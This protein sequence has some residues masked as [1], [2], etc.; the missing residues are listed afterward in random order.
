VREVGDEGRRT[1][2]NTGI[3]VQR[4]MRRIRGGTIKHGWIE[5]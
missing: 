1:K 5:M 4:G 2:R 3:G